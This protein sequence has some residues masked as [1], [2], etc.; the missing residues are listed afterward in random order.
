M[1]GP[2]GWFPDPGRAHPLRWWDGNRWTDWVSDGHLVAADASAPA[3]R[4]RPGD[5]GSPSAERSRV[6]FVWLA[7]VIGLMVLGLAMSVV[8]SVAGGAGDGEPCSGPELDRILGVPYWV[9]WGLYVALAIA[10]LAIW[11]RRLA[12]ALRVRP[13]STNDR[14][15]LVAMGALVALG[16]V[17]AA[18]AFPVVLWAVNGVN[19]GL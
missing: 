14:V 1:A 6:G 11:G 15:L 19:C 10:G 5:G 7:A 18:V 2:P 13:V 16:W 8:P 4:Q 17:A 9:M 12:V 3:A